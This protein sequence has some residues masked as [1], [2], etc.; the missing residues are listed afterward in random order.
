MLGASI[1]RLRVGLL[2]RGGGSSRCFSRVTGPLGALNARS[3]RRQ[4]SCHHYRHLPTH[5]RSLCHGRQGRVVG[6]CGGNV[7]S[8]AG[9]YRWRAAATGEATVRRRVNKEEK[10]AGTL[11]L[12]SKYRRLPHFICS[13]Y[14]R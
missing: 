8:G 14:H 3:Y 10:L 7:S 12:F 9:G 13:L 2:L 5:A 4:T 11:K 1:S 6:R